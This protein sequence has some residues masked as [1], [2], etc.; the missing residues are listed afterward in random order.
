ME[1]EELEE[2]TKLSM[3]GRDKGDSIG[4]NEEEGEEEEEGQ[5]ERKPAPQ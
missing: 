3:I 4:A 5:P 1:E 2:R